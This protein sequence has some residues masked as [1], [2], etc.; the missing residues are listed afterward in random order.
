VEEVDR[1]ERAKDYDGGSCKALMK[2]MLDPV[3]S[4]DD[5]SRDLYDVATWE[6]RS[7]LDRLSV[8]VY[9]GAALLT[10]LVV[11]L[12]AVLILLAQFAYGALGALAAPTVGV[13]TLLSLVPA[14]VLAGYVYIT[15]VTTSEPLELL[16]GTYLLGVLFAGFA[17]IANSAAGVGTDTSVLL[18]VPLFYLV[19]GPVEETV[20]WLAIRLYAFRSDRFDAVIDG[21]VYGAVAGLG[22]ASIENA[23][24]ITQEVS[25]PAF[26]NIIGAGSG[27][28]FSRALAG[29][30]HVIYSAFAGYYL[31]LAKFNREHAGPI[32]VK[33]LLIAAFIHATY[34]VLVGVIPSLATG[35]LPLSPLVATVG[36]VAV[37]DGVLV[38]LLLRKLGRYH[39]AYLSSHSEERAATETRTDRD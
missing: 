33:G 15:D 35:L 26:A 20:K 31:G 10:R 9:R 39:S 3:Q 36:F 18:L 27:I 38:V 24:Y 28:T 34:N 12:L 29:P 8:V 22:F 16:V 21:A 2:R 14:L 6:V 25:N 1:N 11:V 19:V 13:F 32:A 4:R 7:R 5:D 17:G 23:L 30:G 37:Y